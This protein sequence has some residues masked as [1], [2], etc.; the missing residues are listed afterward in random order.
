MREETGMWEK[1]EETEHMLGNSRSPLLWSADGA[2]PAQEAI[3][4][5][6]AYTGQA[7]TATQNWQ[8]LNA[9]R[10]ADRENI[11]HAWQEAIRQPRPFT[12]FYYIDHPRAGYRPF[13][14]LHVPFFNE[15]H[16]LQGWL[17]FFTE[18]AASS[19][20]NGEDWEIRLIYGMIY[21]QVVLG[22][23][24]L[25]LDGTILRANARL[26][27]LTGYAEEEL[28]Q[29]SIW[30]LSLPEDLHLHLQAM[31]ERLA[32]DSSYP[33]FRIRYQRKD[34]EPIWVR[35]TQFLVRQPS[36]EPYYF[37]FVVEDISAQIQAEKEHA[38]LLAR[39]QEAHNEAVGR[40]L[41]LEAVFESLTDGVMVCD[42]HGQ[43]IQAN[44][45]VRRLLHLDTCPDFLQLSVQQRL[46][47]LK[48]FDEQGNELTLE[49]WPLTRLL[50]GEHLPGA[51]E[52]D[53]CLLLP[54]GEKIYVN[55]TGTTMRDQEN[56]IIGAVLIIHDVNE[57]HLLENRIRKSFRILLALAEELVDI[58]GHYQEN[59]PGDEIL[60]APLATHPFRAAGEYLTALTC[61]MLEYQGVSICQID[62]DTGLLHMLAISGTTKE[63]R[64]EYYQKYDRIPLDDILGEG[65]IDLLRNNEVVVKD[66]ALHVRDCNIHTIL[67]A[68]ML[69]DG[70]LVG[71]LSVEKK[72]QYA[73]YS[74]EEIS[75]VKAI[76]KF[77]LLVIERDRIQRE[78]IVAHSSEMTLREANRRFDEFLSL[79]SHEL[80]TPLA[81]IKGNI[82]LALRRLSTLRSGKLPEIHILL[83]KLEKMQNFLSEAENRVNVQN[84]MISDLLDVSRI[85]ANKL[86]LVMGPCDLGN[87]VRNAVKDQR[88]NTPGRVITLKAFGSEGFTVIGDSDRLSQ[89][90]HNYLSNALKYSPADQP[91]LVSLEQAGNNV[92]VSVNDKGP[93]LSPE[94]QRRVW[95]RFYRV[96]GIPT[97]G[98]ASQGLG[99]GLHICRTI[100]EAHQ[101]NFGL[102]S[103]PG[104]GCSFWFSLPLERSIASPSEPSSDLLQQHT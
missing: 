16:Q 4:T 25:S 75:L 32:S 58:P 20:G 31:R 73:S 39:V 28:L 49:Q 91:I 83:D 52:N 24:C 89:V 51:R 45:A 67:L 3:S 15:R 82:Q 36:G 96:K 101:G 102:K 22:I 48:A 2:G 40:S 74:L 53:M 6:N 95:E 71:V 62:S 92:R 42:K 100:I 56:E 33:P 23:F 66:L 76:A 77:M 63:S 85:Q 104:Q 29:M 18:E 43:V 5:W 1:G 35:V 93:G 13:K 94:E 30:Q 103:T 54:D 46:S 44:S 90:V 26:S 21:T 69:L 59:M 47:L 19:P 72:E 70:R 34:G 37:F 99:L 14:V 68:P 84:R 50:R 8:W 88:Y 12:L 97:Q 79:A 17:N 87:I 41:Q 80:R 9:L 55:H 38:E 10:A 60:N 57:R 86:E 64:A 98:S 27:Q 7:A 61:Q 65:G 81:G 78:W 11:R